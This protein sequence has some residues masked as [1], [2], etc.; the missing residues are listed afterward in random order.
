MNYINQL[1]CIGCGQVK[2]ESRIYV[3]AYGGLTLCFECLKFIKAERSEVAQPCVPSVGGCPEA[4]ADGQP[5]TDSRERC[6]EVNGLRVSDALVRDVSREAWA[7]LNH[8]NDYEDGQAH[9]K[10]NWK[11]LMNRIRS[12]LV[13]HQKRVHR[14]PSDAGPAEGQR[15]LPDNDQAQARPA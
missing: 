6:P 11:L 13:A 15:V 2:F 14:K 3:A 5:H 8:D 10:A 7:V 1:P 4:R 9:N 12:V